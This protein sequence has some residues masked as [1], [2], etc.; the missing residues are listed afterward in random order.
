M[1]I[2]LHCHL[3]GSMTRTFLER[4]LQRKIAEEELQ[5]SHDC[6]DLAAYLKKFEL[7]LECLQDKEDFIEA[8]YEFMKSVSEE[9]VDYVEVRFAPLLSQKQGCTT[10][11][12]LEA[13]LKGLERGRREFDI[14]YGVIVCVMR[15]HDQEQSLR[16]VKEAREFLGYGV[17]ALDL[18]GNEMA[19]PMSRFTELFQKVHRYDFPF[20]IHAGECGNAENI[21][22]AVLCGASRIGHGIAM[23]HRPDVMELCKRAYIGVEMCP[24]SNLQTKAVAQDALYPMKK[25][26]DAGILV[27][28]NTDNRTVSNTTLG[29]EMTLVQCKYHITEQEIRQMQK[30]AIEV[31][32]ASDDVKHKL[33][34]KME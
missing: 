10:K 15:H 23:E 24:T 32:F 26:L 33:W 28:I 29:Q 34:N 25:F 3:D 12:I 4:R 1:K 6:T 20:T 16:M 2:D 30:N 8:G 5:V 11:E 7:P 31:S 27:T 21:R 9:G 19:V 17:C 22:E 14:E 18:A 13:L